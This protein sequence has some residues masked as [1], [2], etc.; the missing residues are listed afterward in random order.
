MFAID[1]INAN[2]KSG[3]KIQ[4]PEYIMEGLKWIA[5]E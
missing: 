3:Q 5:K 1:I 2:E 4:V